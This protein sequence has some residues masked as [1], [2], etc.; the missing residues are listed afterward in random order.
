MNF[1]G[2]IKQLLVISTL[3]FI[4]AVSAEE[5]K[6]INFYN[7][8]DYIG[9]DTIANFE[10]EYGIKVN[11]D[12]YDTTNIV[13]A[14]LLAGN[15]GYDVILHSAA[16]SPRLINADVFQPL[17]KSKLD[18][19]RHLDSELM[20]KLAA[21]DPG[22]RY[23]APYM[24][25]TTGISFNVDMLKERIPEVSLDN[26]DFFFDEKILARLADCGV[27]L[28]DGPSDTLPTFMI[29]LGHDANS[30][31]ATHLKEVENLIHSLRPHIKYFSS[32]K[33]LIDMPNGEICA[34][35]SWSGDYAVAKRRAEEAGIDINIGYAMPTK[36]VHVW[37]D[38]L[39]IPAD[40]PHPENAH[41]LINYLMRPDVVA[42][43]SNF[44][45]YANGN[46]AATP[47]LDRKIKDDP[48]IYPDDSIKKKLQP[49]LMY[50]PKKERIRS[51]TWTRVKTG[52]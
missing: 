19:W 33:M 16:F 25:G 18:N 11:Y 37:F 40:A 22:N 8:A 48:G 30:I 24:W 2:T 41:L 46:K 27:S 6:V 31:E 44:T 10:K 28:F 15:S 12:I 39:L 26:A 13:D 5:E 35:M 50:P 49:V 4:S 9:P 34:A 38:I 51:R 45:G 17:D 23:G 3:L 42:A 52:V 47:L 7:W 43:I 32:G 21:F 36:G 29:Y 1:A 14:K 20:N